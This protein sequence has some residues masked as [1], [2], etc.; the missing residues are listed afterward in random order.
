[1][2]SSAIIFNLALYLQ[3]SLFI[4][5]KAVAAF[6]GCQVSKEVLFYLPSY[7]YMSTVFSVVVQYKQREPL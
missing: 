3:D 7:F 1:M 4:A 6:Q 5:N 2:Q